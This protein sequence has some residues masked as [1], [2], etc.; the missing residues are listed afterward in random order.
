MTR[1]ADLLPDIPE[2]KHWGY[3]LLW[4]DYCKGTYDMIGW[5]SQAGMYRLHCRNCN[6][7]V[8]ASAESVTCGPPML[9]DFR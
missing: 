3:Q 7:V 1:L 4:C 2:P 6:M 8:W 9:G 5:D